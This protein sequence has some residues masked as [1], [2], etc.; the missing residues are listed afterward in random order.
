VAY[1]VGQDIEHLRLDGND[2]GSPTQFPAI[3]IER[4]IFK[5][6][7]QSTSWLP[8]MQACVRKNQDNLRLN[9]GYLKDIGAATR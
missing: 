5:K 8:T 7:D 1:Q 3:D 4:I 6:V 9:Q 2:L